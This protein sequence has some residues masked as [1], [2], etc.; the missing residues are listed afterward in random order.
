MIGFIKNNPLLVLGLALIIALLLVLALIKATGNSPASKK[1][2]PTT[3]PN[4]PENPE[5]QPIEEKPEKKKKEKKEKEKK[6]KKEK[7]QKEP[8]KKKE[9]KKKEKKQKV[10]KEKVKKEKTKKEKT[11]KE[12]ATK[13]KDKNKKE[14]K[15]DDKEKKVEPV[16]KTEKK[17]ETPEE[18]K[19]KEEKDERALLEAMAFVKTSKTVSKLAKKEWIEKPIESEFTTE[20]LIAIDDVIREKEILDEN[21]KSKHFDKSI[22]LSNFSQSTDRDSMFASHISDSRTHVNAHSHLNINDNF[23]EGLYER[24]YTALERSGID[25]RDEDNNLILSFDDDDQIAEEAADQREEFAYMIDSSYK[26]TP[27]TQL[28]ESEYLDD[29]VNL[30]PENIL[31]VDS[32]M[33]RKNRGGRR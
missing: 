24:T 14:D 8:K 27:Q 32:V 10:K 22:R 28:P 2:K 13:K 16:F 6:T 31:V 7:K 23:M 21:K 29:S 12:K 20:E 19:Q 30:G 18:K 11:K 15:Q 5:G 4:N 1:P 26:D 25:S 33:N 3:D 9:K 17:E